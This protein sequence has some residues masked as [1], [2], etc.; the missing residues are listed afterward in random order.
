MRVRTAKKLVQRIDLHYFKRARGLRWWRYALSAALPLV[1]ILWI[2][3]YAAAGNRRPYSAGPVSSAHA[4]AERR[5]EVCHVPAGGPGPGLSRGFRTHVTDQACLT[6]HDAP[7]HTANQVAP[8][9]CSSCH[10]EH[11][12]RIQLAKVDDRLC[13]SCHADITTKTAGHP[14][15]LVNV[16]RFPAAHPEFAVLRN[17]TQDPGGIKFNHAVHMKKEGV[18]GPNGPEQL[19]CAQCHLPEVVRTM[20]RRSIKS[21]LMSPIMYKN[22]CARCHALFFD[23]RIDMPVPHD[24]Q[25]V[26]LGFMKVSLET[27]IARNPGDINK[28]DAMFRRVPLNF[29]RPVEPPARNAAE[30]VTRRLAFDERLMWNKTCAECHVVNQMATANREPQA[31]YERVPVYLDSRITTRWMPRASF[32]HASHQMVRCQSCHAAETST[33]TAD[34]LMPPE[35]TCATCHAPSRGAETR[36]FECHQYH[37]WA[38]AHAVTAGF[39]PGDFK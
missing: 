31:G 19:Q 28:P 4:F 30:W 13:V 11:G 6:C 20:G 23:E 37:D 29:P 14:S 22:N 36:C 27:Y 15:S 17:G 8:P 16:G 5:C 35:A 34:V 7:A 3:G 32:D 2:G 12:G 38:K 18:R 9:A 33:A 39:T 21:G 24:K 25:L 1:A 26:G 10:Q